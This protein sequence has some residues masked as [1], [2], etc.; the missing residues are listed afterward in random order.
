MD[1]IHYE[2]RRSVDGGSSR[3]VVMAY[4]VEASGILP[5]DD[6][7]D[8]DD[9]KQTTNKQTTAVTKSISKLEFKVK[10]LRWSILKPITG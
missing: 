1:K 9:A 7:N 10:Q 2:P 4:R 5:A 8:D 3:P 6:V